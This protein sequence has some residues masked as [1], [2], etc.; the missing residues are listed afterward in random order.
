MSAKSNFFTV[1]GYTF[2]ELDRYPGF[3]SVHY[4][5]APLGLLRKVKDKWFDVEGQKHHH[6]P[7]DAASVMKTRFYKQ[8]REAKSA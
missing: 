6:Q 7:E 2:R 3:F 4:R 5:G 8:L 1:N